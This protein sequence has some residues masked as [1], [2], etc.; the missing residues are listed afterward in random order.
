MNPPVGAECGSPYRT[1]ATP[2]DQPICLKMMTPPPP[3]T[4]RLFRQPSPKHPLRRESTSAPPQAA[5]ICR[6]LA[7]RRFVGLKSHHPTKE[8]FHVAAKFLR[9]ASSQ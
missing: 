1:A 3:A 8:S 4:A 6:L 2:A 7:V 5:H 9:F